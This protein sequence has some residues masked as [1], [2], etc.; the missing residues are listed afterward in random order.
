MATH[1]SILAWRIP[2]TEEPSGLLSLGSHRVGHDWSDLAAAVLLVKNLCKC[3]K[4]MH[5]KIKPNK[6]SSLKKTRNTECLKIVSF[7]LYVL[8]FPTLNFQLIF[9]VLIGIDGIKKNAAYS[10]PWWHWNNCY[11]CSFCAIGQYVFVVPYSKASS[12]LSRSCFFRLRA[13]GLFFFFLLLLLSRFSHVW[14]C[15]TP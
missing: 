10:R 15:A 3:L 14:F 11:H 2:G 7:T 12:F 5:A 6:I 8:F 13:N 1:S 4:T 9:S